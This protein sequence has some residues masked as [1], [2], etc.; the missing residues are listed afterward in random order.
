M[1]FLGLLHIIQVSASN[2]YG[3][4]IA[5]E[6]I[7][8]KFMTVTPQPLLNWAP[9]VGGGLGGLFLISCTTSILC[10]LVCSRCYAMR[11]RSNEFKKVEKLDSIDVTEVS[12]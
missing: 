1:R 4:G 7:L 10:F 8:L 11:R 6:P 12:N 3:R 9:I 2:I 5:S